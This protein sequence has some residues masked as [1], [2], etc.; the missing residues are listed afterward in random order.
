MGG[1][2]MAKKIDTIKKALEKK[3]YTVIERDDT[4]VLAQ[5]LQEETLHSEVFDFNYAPF[6]CASDTHYCVNLEI[7]KITGNGW[8]WE[9]EYPTC[10]KLYKD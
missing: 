1:G 5:E 6:V 7:E 4:L 9:C 2:V 8:L 3:G 10:F